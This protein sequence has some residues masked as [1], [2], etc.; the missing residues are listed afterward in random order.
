MAKP[1]VTLAWGVRTPR[2]LSWGQTPLLGATVGHGSAFLATN[3]VPFALT[4]FNCSVSVPWQAIN[5][6]GFVRPVIKRALRW[7]PFDRWYVAHWIYKR[8]AMASRRWLYQIQSQYFCYVVHCLI[9]STAGQMG[10]LYAKSE[11]Q[12]SCGRARTCGLW[13]C[14]MESRNVKKCVWQP[15]WYDCILFCLCVA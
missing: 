15:P 3:S 14:R 8:F 5:G 1:C 13:I 6:T 11:N 4:N 12:V 10:N 7:R 9:D 2:R